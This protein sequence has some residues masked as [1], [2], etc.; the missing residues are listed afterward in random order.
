MRALADLWTELA[1]VSQLDPA[2]VGP[3]PTDQPSDVAMACFKLAQQT[4]EPPHVVAQQIAAQLSDRP[5]LRTVE[6]VG[7]YVNLSLKSRFL[8]RRLADLDLPATLPTPVSNQPVVVEYCSVNLAKPMSVGHLRNLMLGRALANLHRFVGYRVITDNHIGDWGRIFGIWVAGFRRY[9]DDQRLAD[10]GVDELGRIYVV[11]NRD[12]DSDPGLADE[13]QS[14]LLRLQAGDK[15]ALAYHRRF[16]RISL[17]HVD[18][19]LA[20]FGIK[21]DHVLGESFYQPQIG[22]L[23]DRLIGQGQAVAQK[24]GSV[25]VDL[26]SAG[27][28]TPL[29]IRKSNGGYLYASSDIAAVDWREDNWQPHRVIYVVGAD[30]KFYFRQLFAANQLLGLSQAELIHYAHGL[31]EERSDQGSRQKMSSRSGAINLE[32]VIDR[33]RATVEAMVK[34]TVSQTDQDR[35]VFGALAFL[36]FS[37]SHPTNILFDWQSIFNL[38]GHSG[39]Y[40]QYAVVRLNSILSKAGADQPRPDLDNYSWQDEHKILTRLLS[41]PD[42]LSQALEELEPSRI[43]NH[44]WLLARQFNRYYEKTPVSGADSS[45]RDSRLWLV[46]LAA[47]QMTQALGLLG[48][49]VPGEM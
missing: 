42:V 39:P 32:A 4:Q 44:V 38:R 41:Y 27:I 18:R 12:L 20:L 10:G 31:I 3:S 28:K 26:S 47:E 7:G 30:Q 8:A 1:K 46:G 17:D 19:V 35:I 40:V 22:P 37:H 15:E 5:E 14:W 6:A 24:D 48:I 25:I 2:R 11:A 49:D 36:E 34:P 21:F 13:V 9:S 16:S 45:A 23:I 33:A 29:L 43:A